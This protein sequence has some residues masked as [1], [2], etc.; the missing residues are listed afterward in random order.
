VV[1]SVIALIAERPDDDRDVVSQSVDELL[2]SV[3]VG[4]FP[5]PDRDKSHVS[6][7]HMYLIPVARKITRKERG[8][9]RVVGRPL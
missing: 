1:A 2:R 3:N 7:I 9:L 8:D 5:L 6:K 4:V